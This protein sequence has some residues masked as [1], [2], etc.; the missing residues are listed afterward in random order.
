MLLNLNQGTEQQHKPWVQRIT[1]FCQLPPSWIYLANN[2]YDWTDDS[3]KPY[4][5]YWSQECICEYTEIN[6]IH[7]LC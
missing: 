3:I 6:G 2:N 1:D 5:I 4:A 7:L